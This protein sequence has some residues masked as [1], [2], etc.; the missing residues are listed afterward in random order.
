[1][2]RSGLSHETVVAMNVAAALVANFFGAVLVAL[3][4]MQ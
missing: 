1:M 3:A 2:D 4:S